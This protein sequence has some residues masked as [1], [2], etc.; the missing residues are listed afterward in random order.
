[1]NPLEQAL[2][3]AISQSPTIAVL[4]FVYFGEKKRADKAESE[5][6]SARREHIADMRYFS[7]RPKPEDEPL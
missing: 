5:K 7:R 2:I 4:L 3:T 6:D 1:M